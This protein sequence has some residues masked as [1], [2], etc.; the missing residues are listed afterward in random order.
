MRPFLYQGA[1]GLLLFLCAGHPH[2]RPARNAVDLNSFRLSPRAE[3]VNYSIRGSLAPYHSSIVKEDYVQSAT[4]LVRV[5][6]PE[7]SFRLIDNHYI[8]DNGIGHVYY[9]QTLYGIDIE[10]ADFNVNVGKNGEIFSY[11]NSFFAG[12]FSASSLPAPS[13]LSDPRAAFRTVIET[14]HLPIA[15]DPLSTRPVNNTYVLSGTGAVSD[16]T[17]RLVYLIT[18]ANKL[19]LTWRIELD[20]YEHW[21]ISYVDAASSNTIHGIID[22]VYE[23][24][25]QVYPW[26]TNDPSEGTRSIVS[27][28]WDLTSSPYTW[29]SDGITNYTTTRGNNAIAQWN[30]SGGRSYRNNY[31]PSS[32][33]LQFHYPY[34]T[35]Q[36][37]PAAYIN[38]SITQLFYTVNAYH[39]LLYQL[40]FTEAA[41]NF[42]FNNGRRGGRA[43]DYVILNAQDG[44]GTDNANFAA[45]P[46]GI[47][48]RMCMFLWVEPGPSTDTIRDGSFDTGIVIHEYTHGLSTRLTGGPHNAGCLSTLES[49]GMGEGWGDFMATAIRVKPGDSRN[50]SYTVGAWAQANGAGVRAYPYST[51]MLENPLMYTHV[52]EFEGVHAIGTVWASMLYEVMWNLMER[53]GFSSQGGLGGNPWTRGE[54]TPRA[55][56]GRYLA[57]KLVVDGMALQPCNPTFVQARDAILDA[58][59]ALTG[60]KNRCEIWKGFAKRG[61]GAGARYRRFRRV[62]SMT[63][64]P[65]VCQE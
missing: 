14:L 4:E 17:V 10:N 21:L 5:V 32:P 18:S 27:N 42:E 46:D 56:D 35:S 1:L 7:T 29:H 13:D 23:A 9:R 20:I 48:A 39:D 19:I 59:V 41:G 52:N 22:Y 65:G 26:G 37:T 47:P 24:S 3:Y 60:G 62:G 38:A 50:S 40:G 36:T 57:M 6:A 30:P 12:D 64:P 53:Y 11:G 51:S 15:V 34:A 63:V 31:R 25:Y 58:D 33:T 43:H 28:P 49:A 44:S 8:G 16:P 55:M 45:P 2:Q 61:L 54:A